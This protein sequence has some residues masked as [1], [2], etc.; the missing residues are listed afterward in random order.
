M[1]TRFSA[2]RW[3]AIAAGLAISLIAAFAIPLAIA[4][5]VEPV[6]PPIEVVAKSDGTVADLRVSDD[7]VVKKGDV[8]LI[9][10]NKALDESIKQL[11]AK[12]EQLKLDTKTVVVDTSMLGAIGTMPIRYQAPKQTTIPTP[13]PHLES[14][15]FSKELAASG[16]ALDGLA[17]RL[18]QAQADATEKRDQIEEASGGIS[19]AQDEM[20]AAKTAIDPADKELEKSKRLYDIGAIAKRKLDSSEAASQVAHD[21]AD[22]AAKALADANSR[23]SELEADL[24]K[25]NDEV[26]TLLSKLADAQTKLAAVEKKS[27]EVQPAPPATMMERQIELPKRRIAFGTAPIGSTAPL[28]VKLVDDSTPKE[29][30]TLEQLEAQL[31]ALK[32]KKDDLIIRSP[33]SGTVELKKSILGS[34]LKSG[35]VILQIHPN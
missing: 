9:L 18:K 35:Q 34:E 4:P 1:S 15:D 19:Q 10:E 32:Q 16:K 31:K 21:R 30:Q 22:S 24:K 28:P 12:I 23:K 3:P 11:E 20:D 7:A 33:L 29:E 25:L 14:P 6:V 5:R 13:K 2:Y 17:A 27:R 26:E 8:L